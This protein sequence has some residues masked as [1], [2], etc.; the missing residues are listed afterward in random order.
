MSGSFYESDGV[1]ILHGDCRELLTDIDPATVALVLTDPPYGVS[2][3]TNR[4][5][6]GRTKAAEC[7][8]FPPVYG[9]D[10]PFDPTHLFRFKRLVLWGANYYADRLPTSPSWLVWDKRDGL[11]SNDNAD[12]EL[13]WTNLGGPARSYRHMWNGMV[14]ASERTERRCH[15]TQKP[16][17]L[18]S[19]II[20]NRTQPGDLILDPYMGGGSTLV[21]A[22]RA[23]R[24]AIGIEYEERYCETAAARLAQGSLFDMGAVVDAYLEAK[25]G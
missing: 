23:G 9:D 21:A 3:P 6:R 24:R 22:K 18:M 19:W 4:K 15:P 14:K 12:V 17:S 8:D 5:E 25:K 13:A 2:E 20:E 7:N 16:V 10:Q 1:T 11:P